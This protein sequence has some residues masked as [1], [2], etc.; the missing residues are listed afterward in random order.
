MFRA[1]L[2]REDSAAIAERVAARLQRHDVL[3]RDDRP[4]L[5]VILD[6]ACLRR[7]VGSPEIMHEQPAHLLAMSESPHT[8][9]QV[10]PFDTGAPPAGESYTLLRFGDQP[11]ALYTEA[12]GL[13][14]VVDEATSVVTATE[15][16]ERLRADA[17]SPQK[18]LAEMHKVMEELRR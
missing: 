17:L 15:D 7:T 5:W 3:D 1:A 4:L 12:R 10:I 11:T 2:P 8:T 18:A 16:Y 9:L 14:R 13:G 6:E